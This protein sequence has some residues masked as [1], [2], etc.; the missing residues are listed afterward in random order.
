[1]TPDFL[2]EEHTTATAVTSVTLNKPA[3][4]VDGVFMIAQVDCD[5]ASQ[6]LVSA[7]GTTW[8]A[9]D[10]DGTSGFSSGVMYR[11]A[12]ASEPST[13]SFKRNDDGSDNFA[14][15][16]TAYVRVDPTYPIGDEEV[17]LIATSTTLATTAISNPM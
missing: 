2:S 13:Y 8:T 7:D 12:G 4:V 14:A 3:G 17:L 15:S 9:F 6:T 10:N 1:M 16:I 11:M 5:A